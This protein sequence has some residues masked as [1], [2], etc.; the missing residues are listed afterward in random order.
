MPVMGMRVHLSER[1]DLM[2]KIRV[3]RFVAPTLDPR[4]AGVDAAGGVG[5]YRG[6][7][8]HFDTGC[9]LVLEDN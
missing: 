1:I 4:S 6:K 5:D 3:I 8:W 2:S 9:V 7:G